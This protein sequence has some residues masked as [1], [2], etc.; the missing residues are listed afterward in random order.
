MKFYYFLLLK[1]F[2]IV[3]KNLIIRNDF[4]NFQVYHADHISLQIGNINSISY[5]P[6]NENRHFLKN[7]C[8]HVDTKYLCTV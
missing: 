7:T 1:L 4:F 5:K 6:E 8:A 3:K 2:K